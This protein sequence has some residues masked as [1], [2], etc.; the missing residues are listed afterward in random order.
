M[1]NQ[2][3]SSWR[4]AFN[5]FHDALTRQVLVKRAMAA[6]TVNVGIDFATTMQLMPTLLG[7]QES[8]CGQAML[9]RSSKT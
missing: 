9:R 7:W 5:S 2:S 6:M 8:D 4:F 3:R 1:A